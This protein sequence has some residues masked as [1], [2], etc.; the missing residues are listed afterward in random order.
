MRARKPQRGPEPTRWAKDSSTPA[1][2]RSK[3]HQAQVFQHRL[4]KRGPIS[5]CLF[6][7]QLAWP[8]AYDEYRQRPEVEHLVGRAAHDHPDQ[9]GKT[10]RTDHDERGAAICRLFQDRRSHSP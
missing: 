6:G 5:L 2:G 4:R 10:T 7:L 8:S 3:D 9:V 1:Q